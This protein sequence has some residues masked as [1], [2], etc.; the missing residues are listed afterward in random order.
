MEF[1]RLVEDDLRA[2]S[3]EARKK[4]P[5][6]KEAA[7]RGIVKLR[8]LREQYAAAV[9]ESG[10]SPPISMLRS[11][12]LLRP[13]LLALNH[14]DCSRT[15]VLQAL[16]ALQRLINRGAI[17]A[18]DAPNILRVLSIQATASSAAQE[19]QVKVLQ[20]LL[21]TVTWRSC[22]LP[23]DSLAS[24]LAVCIQ[25]S[26]QRNATVKNAASATLRQIISLMFDRVGAR[27]VEDE[28]D[29]RDRSAASSSPLRGQE[30]DDED[31]EEEDLEWS[32]QGQI[33]RLEAQQ[34]AQARRGEPEGLR[35]LRSVERCAYYLLQDLCLLSRGESGTWLKHVTVPQT[36]G[37]E[38]IEQI[39]VHKPALFRDKAV[40]TDVVRNQVCPLVVQTL[41]S[42]LDFPLLVRLMRTVNTV[43]AELTDLLVPQ[44]EVILTMLT[45][46]ISSCELGTSSSSLTG[47]V[48]SLTSSPFIQSA[49]EGVVS[50][51]G[52]SSH[53]RA[54]KLGLWSVL[55]ALDVISTVCHDGGLLHTVF[56]NYDLLPDCTNIFATLVKT[57]TRFVMEGC[58]HVGASLSLHSMANSVSWSSKGLANLSRGFELLKETAPPPLSDGEIL[59]SALVCLLALLDS[60]SRLT[61]EAQLEGTLPSPVPSA[62][63]WLPG[64]GQE[65]STPGYLYHRMLVK[66]DTWRDLL[67]FLSTMFSSQSVGSEALYDACLL[68][69]ERLALTVHLVGVAAAKPQVRG[70][71]WTML[72]HLYSNR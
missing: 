70:L 3:V 42:G 54:S 21:L 2:V 18:G 31:D 43:V 36:M 37:L 61:I 60:L 22:E 4:H 67:Q 13:F 23:E 57:L 62:A 8:G 11:Q 46:L 19:V 44:C 40:F 38:L 52:F 48:S 24:A 58:A 66:G 41:K 9:R 16:A 71:A 27:D 33:R 15:M 17:S 30:E 49:A 68:G 39:L 25:L 5:M 56:R 59:L 47:G 35:M 14:S 45:Q 51:S 7:E 50:L 28:E 34:R 26:E 72:S 65:G 20:T 29:E 64:V 12:D 63:L 53:S 55:L 69:F 6:V 1:L 10:E 32:S